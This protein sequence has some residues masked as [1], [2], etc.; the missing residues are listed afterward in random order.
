MEGAEA[1]GG[2]AAADLTAPSA[3]AA[4]AA[5]DAFE[6]GPWGR[7]FPTVVASWRRAW[8]HVIPFL[9]FPPD[10][11]RVIYTTNALESVHA[12]LRKI[13]KTRGHFPND[14]AATKLIWLALR[15]I[16]AKWERGPRFW[17]TAMN[18]FAILYDD[19]FTDAERV[20]SGRGAHGRCRPCGRTERAHRDLENRTDTRFPTAPTR[21]IVCVI[22]RKTEERPLRG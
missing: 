10:V 12:Q 15:N 7:K 6:R 8:T 20:K 3:E 13:I 11:R 14:E 16:T 18:Q 21:I 9:A 17:K 22:E 5:L 1:D 19:R 4:G 2:G